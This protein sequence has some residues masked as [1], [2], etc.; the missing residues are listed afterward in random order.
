MKTK[1]HPGLTVE[2]WGLQ[3]YAQQV[4]QVLS[5][6][7]RAKRWIKEGEDAMTCRSL[8][9]ALELMD[10]TVSANQGRRP[11]REL[12]RSREVVAGF[13]VAP[14]KDY[15]EFVSLLKGL[16]TLDRDIPERALG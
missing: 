3:P 15:A 1:F 14:T 10:L 12:L 2:R 11:L 6:L 13:Y 4:L 7:N 8:E 5:E 9:R 16:L